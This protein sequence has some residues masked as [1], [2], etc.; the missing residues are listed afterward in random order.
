MNL[1]EKERIGIIG[2]MDAEVDLIK[3]DCVI[4]NTR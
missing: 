2:A 4:E 3:R 1:M